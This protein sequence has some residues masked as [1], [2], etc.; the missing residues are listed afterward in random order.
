MRH[1]EDGHT[2]EGPGVSPHAGRR[3][4]RDSAAVERLESRRLRG[5]NVRGGRCGPAAPVPG[6]PRCLYI[7]KDLHCPWNSLSMEGPA[8]ACLSSV[9]DE[10]CWILST[11]V[12]ATPGY[13]AVPPPVTA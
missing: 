5:Y 11:A 1:P 7:A 3:P 6:H 12:A 13:V 4:T 10:F 2:A 9:E 8:P